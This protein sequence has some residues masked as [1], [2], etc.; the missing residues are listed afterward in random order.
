[1]FSALFCPEL[2]LGGLFRTLCQ[3]ILVCL[4]VKLVLFRSCLP[5][6]DK[7]PLNG[8]GT[9]AQKEALLPQTSRKRSFADIRFDELY[10]SKF[11]FLHFGAF[12]DSSITNFVNN[13][14]SLC[15]SFYLP[16]TLVVGQYILVNFLAHFFHGFFFF[17]SQDDYFYN[18][19]SL[20]TVLKNAVES[21][22]VRKA[23]YSIKKSGV[24]F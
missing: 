19:F 7:R 12:Y 17:P 3:E 4:N 13:S 5:K 21:V 23:V 18:S 15:F 8:S 1:M 9:F 11:H 24:R 20:A 14:F 16:C 10:K 2:C 6:L 22:P